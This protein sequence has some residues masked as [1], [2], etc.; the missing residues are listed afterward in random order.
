ML[1]ILLSTLVY[2]IMV[3]V[4][5]YN[6][7]KTLNRDYKRTTFRK[8][9]ADKN[10]LVPLILFSFLAAIR[11]DVGVDCRS[12]FYGFYREATESELAK[13]EVLFYWIQDVFKFINLSHIPFFFTIAFIQISFIYYGLRKKPEILLFFPL[14]FVLYGTFW[15]Y[16]NGVR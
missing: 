5:T 6:A 3:W 8:F 2:G 9:I 11:W 7:Q 14:L 13:G 15:S 1:K 12:Y 10:I 4:M 16:M